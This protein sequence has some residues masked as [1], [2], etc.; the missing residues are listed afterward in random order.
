MSGLRD[1]YTSRSGPQAADDLTAAMLE[2]LVTD[3]SALDALADRL[4]PRLADRLGE[5]RDDEWLDSTRAA[6]YL[7]LSRHA[8]HRLTAARAIPFSQDGPGARCWFRRSELDGWREQSR[9]EGR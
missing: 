8:L 7:G 2:L 5:R 6:S 1:G 9:Q 3:D 4:A